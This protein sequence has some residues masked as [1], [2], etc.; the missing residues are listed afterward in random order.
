MF[1]L[2]H[3]FQTN[4]EYK[5]ADKVIAVSNATAEEAIRFYRLP[6]NRVV[7]INNGMNLPNLLNSRVKKENEEQIILSVGRLVWNKGHKYLVDAMPAVLSECPSARLFI[8][9]VGDQ[10]KPLQSQAKKLHIE[11]AVEFLGK[12]STEKLHSLYSEADVFVH[13]S[14]YDPAPIA[15]LEAMSMGKPVVAT[16]VGG[17]PEFITNGVDGLLVEPRNSS[18]LARAITDILSD[19]SMRRRLGQEAR[20]RIEK[21][22]TWE[23]VAKKTLEF[24]ESLLNEK[25]MNLAQR[26]NKASRRIK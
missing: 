25:R 12:V 16:H 19:S 9:G 24:Y 8:V 10:R 22:F 18:Q 13:P 20:K 5:S 26:V 7:A 2:I 11:G 14:L 23:A 17:I 3:A 1:M 4:I 21:E 6:R 15:V